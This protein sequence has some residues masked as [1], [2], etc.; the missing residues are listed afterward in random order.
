MG[1]AA[2]AQQRA[3]RAGRVKAGKAYR[4][5]TEETFQ[6]LRS[7]AIPEI[8]RSNLAPVILQLKAL[9]VHNIARFDFMSPPPA[10]LMSRALEILYA[11]GLIDDSAQLTV[12]LGLKTAEF[13]LDVYLAKVVRDARSAVRGHS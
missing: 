9:G 4:L 12:P 2:S 1:R 13:P 5:Y 8:Q 10:E 6:Q 7:T 11:L 3:G